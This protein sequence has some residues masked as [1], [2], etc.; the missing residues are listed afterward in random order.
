[1]EHLKLASKTLA[2]TLEKHLKPLQKH[3]K[4]PDKIFATYV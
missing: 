1:M 4:Y 2:K 3:M